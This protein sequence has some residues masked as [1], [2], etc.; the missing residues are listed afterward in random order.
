MAATAVERRDERDPESLAERI[1]TQES[2][3]L[4]DDLAGT[5]EIKLRREPILD[6][7]EAGLIEPDTVRDDPFAV[8][9]VGE[10]VAVEHRQ[11][12]RAER[13]D[14][15]GIA[16]VGGRCLAGQAENLDRVDCLGRNVERVASSRP[17]DQR[18]VTERASE[19]GNLGL[20]RVAGD[21]HRVVRPEIL[22]Q[23][24]G[25]HHD[26]CFQRESDEQLGR[27]AGPH[28]DC[29][30]VAVKFDRA[31]HRDRDHTAPYDARPVTAP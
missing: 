28:G 24:I 4:G 19:P 23:P 26:P 8:A 27:L 20:Q 16:R 13:E 1:A 17:G 12:R 6:E 15:C 5:T 18:A 9:G 14:R 11:R 3:D 22:D 7:T 10:N 31:E 21:A 25:S 29:D 2:F 30:V